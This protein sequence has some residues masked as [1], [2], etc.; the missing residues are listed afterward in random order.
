VQPILVADNVRVDVAGV[1]VVERLSFASAGRRVLVLGAARALFEAAAGQ[2]ACAQ[3]ELLLEGKAPLEAVRG[4]VAAGAPLD[5]PLPAAWT[6]AEYVGWSA[7]I[8]GLAKA[9]AVALAEQAVEAMELGAFRSAKLGAASRHVRR[10]TVVTAAL[11]TGAGTVVLEDPLAGLAPEV[12]QSLARR[13]ATATSGRRAVI[14]ASRVPLES[15]IAVAADEAIVV[16]GSR[17]AAQ[18][19]PAEVAASAG[20]YALRVAGDVAAFAEAV[21]ARGAV[22]WVP[23]P[24]SGRP[25]GARRLSVELGPLGTRDLLRL[26]EESRAVVLELR[27]IGYAF[28]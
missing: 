15:P 19:T 18:G 12:A 7:R 21:R 11:A 2:R 10:A 14:F 25:A 17:I 26:A 3:G 22:V 5:P 4:R 9:S 1:P 28:A 24:S 8:A 6:V 23:A 16:D 13:L 27:P 20:T